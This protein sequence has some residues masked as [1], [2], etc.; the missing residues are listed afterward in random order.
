MPKRRPQPATV[1][2][3]VA[4]FVALGGTSY[5][6]LSVTGKNVKNSSLTGA[7]IKNSSI[8]GTDVKNRSLRA[9]DFRAGELP[10]GA[11]GPQGPQGLKGDTGAK[12]DKGDAG[13]PATRLWASINNAN[14]PTILHGQGVTAVAD[15]GYSAGSTEV[16]FDRDVSACAFIV[17]PLGHGGG[18]L[19][20]TVT[21]AVTTGFYAGSSLT[22]QQVRVTTYYDDAVADRD[23]DIV[24]FC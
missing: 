5:A 19:T 11:Q 10:A 9:V 13:T 1:I 23:Y 12:G 18:Y 8:T 4:L 2:S 21:A 3:L 15:S 24:A 16:T 22:N 7:D 6:A 20:P 17:T 14:P